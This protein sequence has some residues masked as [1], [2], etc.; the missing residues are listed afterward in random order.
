M[1]LSQEVEET[2]KKKGEAEQAATRKAEKEAAAKE[3]QKRK[4]AEE[5]NVK[6]EKASRTSM[7]KTAGGSEKE[8]KSIPKKENYRVSTQ[9]TP[10]ALA[11]TE[12]CTVSSAV[13]PVFALTRRMLFMVHDAAWC[14][15]NHTSPRPMHPIGIALPTTSTR[16]THA[17][18][19]CT[20]TG[21]IPSTMHG[22]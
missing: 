8:K 19:I 17:C 20:G 14:G 2:A 12:R 16:L 4:R 3:K 13:A 21:P 9:N 11:S 1:C 18:H 15:S 7:V 6:A 10:D 5:D 22:D